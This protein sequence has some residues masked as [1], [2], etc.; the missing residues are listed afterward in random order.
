MA[1]VLGQPESGLDSYFVFKV[2]GQTQ[3]SEI[4]RQMRNPHWDREF[5]FRGIAKDKE[6]MNAKGDSLR[7]YCFRHDPIK[8]DYAIGD[9]TV[10]L[11][12]LMSKQDEHVPVEME[13]E[14]AEKG[15]IEFL[16]EFVDMQYLSLSRLTAADLMEDERVNAEDDGTLKTYVKVLANG[17]NDGDV[18]QTLLNG[19]ESNGRSPVY[20]RPDPQGTRTRAAAARRTCC[21]TRRSSCSWRALRR[22]QYCA[23]ASCATACASARR[24]A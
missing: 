11:G 6:T 4:A 17:T 2:Q 20:D 24:T 1:F 18:H 8:G 21:C 23:A 15:K 3:T 13:L 12:L 10:R 16:L 7:I 9:C 5:Q 14:N 19:D 22:W